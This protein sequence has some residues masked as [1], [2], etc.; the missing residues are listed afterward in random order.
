MIE[1]NPSPIPLPGYQE[2]GTKRYTEKYLQRETLAV[3]G[4]WIRVMAVGTERVAETA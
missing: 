3:L 4:A 1:R 2:D